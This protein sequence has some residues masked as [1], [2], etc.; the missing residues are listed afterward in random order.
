MTK[1]T[2]CKACGDPIYFVRSYGGNYMPVDAEIRLYRKNAFGADQ[3]IT[4]EGDV[5]RCDLDVLPAEA[6]G[7]GYISHFATCPAAAKMRRRG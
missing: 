1:L 4:R 6:D 2:Y 5:I 7:A 3:I